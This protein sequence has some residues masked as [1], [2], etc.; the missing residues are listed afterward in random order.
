LIPSSALIFNAAG[1]NIAV[2]KDDKIHMQTIKIGR[3]LGTEVEIT[4]GLSPQDQVVT[5]P[6]ARLAEGV[7]VQVP[8]TAQASA[9][10]K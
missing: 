8:P 6:G 9:E 5:N 7:A 1:L 2:V 4:K 3:D 10:N